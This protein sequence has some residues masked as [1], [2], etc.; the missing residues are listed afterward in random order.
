MRPWWISPQPCERRL[1]QRARKKHEIC[2]IDICNDTNAGL[3]ARFE[4]VVPR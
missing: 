2:G 1:S 3:Y 4:S